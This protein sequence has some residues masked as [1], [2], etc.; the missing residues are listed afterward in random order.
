M[1]S[2]GFDV[3]HKAETE[4]D[5]WLGAQL[6][7]VEPSGGQVRI[8]VD[9]SSMTRYRI[10][11]VVLAIEKHLTVDATVNFVYSLA[12]FSPPEQMTFPNSHVGPVRPEFAG[13]WK[14]PDLAVAAVVGLG[15]EEDKAL[16]AVEHLQAAEVWA[17]IP[18]SHIAAYTD[19]LQRANRT[20]LD[21]VEP[22]HLL[23][24]RVQDPFECYSRLES[25]VFGLSQTSNVVLLPFGPKIFSLC[26]VL[27]G[28]LHKRVPVWRVSAEGQEPA[29]NR[30]A[31][32]SVYGLEVR[33]SASS[34]D[35]D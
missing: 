24:Y 13:W 33:F 34:N 16:G 28:R 11:S 6:E 25:L 31:S 4:F 1:S 8:V 21:S 23:Q 5:D 2:H 17:F 3:R 29:I 30:E 32:G 20:L 9:I 26:S 27:V 35:L 19:E 10:A 22:E 12:K 14:E 18:R 7:L 15:Y